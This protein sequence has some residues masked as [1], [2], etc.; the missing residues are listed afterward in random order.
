MR[1]IDRDLW[2]RISPILDRA[3]ELDAAERAAFVASV[4]QS[5][6][7]LAGPLEDFL[8]DFD[9]VVAGRFLETPAADQRVTVSGQTVGAY[10]LERA[11]GSGGMGSVWLGRRSDGRFEGNVAVKLLNL[12][13]LDAVGQERFKREGTLLARLSHPNI[14][15]LLD[16]G[17]SAAG[18]PYLVLEYIDGQPIDV[19][20]DERRLSVRQRIELIL[21]VLDAVSHAHANLIVH[22][23]LKPSNILVTADATVKL[24]DF[25][26]A[27]LL[28]DGP[29]SAE[30]LTRDGRPLTPEFAAPEQL[31]GGPIVTATDVYAVGVLLYRLLTGRQPHDLSGR[32]VFEIERLVCHSTPA[33]PSDTFAP[34]A[35]SADDR[36]ARAAARGTSTARLRRSLRGDLDTIVMTALRTEPE[37]RYATVAAFQED[38]RRFLDGRP[39]QA[40]PDSL[41]YR[42]RKFVGRHK[43]GVA[44]ATVLAAVL[45]GG[46]VR[47]RTLRARAEGEARKTKAVEAYLVSVFDVANPFAPPGRRGEDVTARALLDRGAAG[48]GPALDREPEVQAELRGVLGHVYVN[49]GLFDTAEP[50]LRTALE[51]QRALHGDRHADVAAA[52]ARLGDALT[53][54][55][56]YDDAEPLL[57]EAL[58]QR[59]LLLGNAHTDTATSMEHLATLYQE[60]TQYGR[61]EPLFR[62]ALAVRQSIQGR[63]HEDVATSLNNLGLLLQMNGRSDQTEPLYRDALAIRVQRLGEDHPLTAQSAHNLA[64]LLQESGRITEAESLYRRALAAKRKSLGNA[65][66]SVTVNLNNLANLL[67]IEQGKV[68]EAEALVREALALDRQMFRAPHAYIAESLR[69]L[70]IVLRLKGDF[71]GAE[72]T[73]RE[74]LAMNQTLFG[75]SHLRIASL[76][77]QLGLTRHAK[78]DLSAAIALFRESREQYA[79]LV[80]EQH[81]NYLTVSN[82]LAGALREH[83]DSGEAEALFRGTASRLKADVRAHREQL[84][85]AQVG[86]GVCLTR[87]GRAPE[88]LPLLESALALSRERFG[89]DHWRSG[90]AQLAL[91]Q[92]LLES[93]DRIRAEPMLREAAVKVQSQRR[94]QPSLVRAAELA[95]AAARRR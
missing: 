9:D 30:A 19:F 60:R 21:A 87:R 37:R 10:T 18:Q 63:G 26:I 6:P 29:Q 38:L 45:A 46:V 32:T 27:R 22:R 88:A 33:R 12:A 48:I 62:E 17:V 84:I 43:A 44:A 95:D 58:A 91:G 66:P 5:S 15:R 41:A 24:L 86:L 42:A 36:T 77:N 31:C 20:A 3:L 55:S 61:A 80:G 59:R 65:H 64:Q 53:R 34:N 49:L 81:L 35:G 54:M 71:D 93:N 23:D 67:A 4:R 73:F 57:R 72:R 83:G 85:A 94:A 90:E 52:M 50:L 16:A 8:S 14:A 68:D 2:Q 47:E 13:L 76:L 79:R 92:A 7:E 40:R 75:Q 74:A 39:V 89:A 25:G 70:G 51:Q 69:R 11:L 78:E 82:N 1:P 56:R 28:P